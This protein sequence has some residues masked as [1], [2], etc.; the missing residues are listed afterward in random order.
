MV[1]SPKYIE[2]FIIGD[3][4]LEV[5]SDKQITAVHLS[6]IFLFKHNCAMILGLGQ[7]TGKDG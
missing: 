6:A 4:A 2:P 7:L 1:V 5:S 3:I